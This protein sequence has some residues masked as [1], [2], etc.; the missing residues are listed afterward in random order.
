MPVAEAP[1]EIL[2]HPRSPSVA[3]LFGIETE[4]QA[5]AAEWDRILAVGALEPQAISCRS[6]SGL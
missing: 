1:E 4:V 2:L 5:L 6:R 3:R